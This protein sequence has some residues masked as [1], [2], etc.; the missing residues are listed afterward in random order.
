M[1]V[2][3]GLE[4]PPCGQKII[5]VTEFVILGNNLPFY[6]VENNSKQKFLDHFSPSFQ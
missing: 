2:K 6:E 5:F 1:I 4:I 3:S